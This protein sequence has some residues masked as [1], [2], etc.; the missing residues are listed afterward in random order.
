MLPRRLRS[1][2]RVRSGPRSRR[3]LREVELV[4]G[5]QRGGD[6]VESDGELTLTEEAG[7]NVRMRLCRHTCLTMGPYT[8]YVYKMAR[9]SER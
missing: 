1:S 8:L 7:R 2:S 6:V 9:T 3:A 4:D 5:S